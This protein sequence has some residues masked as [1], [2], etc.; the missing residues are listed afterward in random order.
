MEYIKFIRKPD[1]SM[2]AGIM[3]N[4][5][6]KL[7]YENENVKQ[8]LE[9]LKLHT[10]MTIKNQEYESTYDTTIK[11]KEGDVLIF[12]EKDRGYIKPIET[13]M[14]ITEAIEELKCIEDI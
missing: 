13:F 8:T 12:E 4:K 3:V 11:L 7:T 14:T 2:H 6:T 10:I 9:N 5:D 1:I